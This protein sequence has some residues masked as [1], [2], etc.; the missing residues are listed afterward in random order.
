MVIA[1]TS[2]IEEAVELK[3]LVCLNIGK[4][5][6]LVRGRGDLLKDEEKEKE[7]REEGKERG[8]KGKERRKNEK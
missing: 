7:R 2:F 3:A 8:E 4:G 1:V 5:E 6:R